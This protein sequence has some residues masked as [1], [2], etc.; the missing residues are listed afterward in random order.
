MVTNETEKIYELKEEIRVLTEKI[1]LLEKTIKD[2]DE[3]IELLRMKIGEKWFYLSGVTLFFFVWGN[4]GTRLGKEGSLLSGFSR[5]S[6]LG[7]G[8]NIYI[9]YK[10]G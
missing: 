2:K 8:M 10:I 6:F 3:I 5:A 4:S 9:M 1:D 7:F